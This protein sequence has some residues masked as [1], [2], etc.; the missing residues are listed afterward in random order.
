[1]SKHLA[2]IPLLAIIIKCLIIVAVN[3]VNETEYVSTDLFTQKLVAE[4]GSDGSLDVQQLGR[5]LE[6]LGVFDSDL[7]DGGAGIEQDATSVS[8]FH[9]YLVSKTQVLWFK[10]ILTYFF[11]L[12]H[13]CIFF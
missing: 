2:R 3:A 6:K 7:A 11:N 13:D 5:I 1:M 12:F 9:S 8:V 4:F 10:F